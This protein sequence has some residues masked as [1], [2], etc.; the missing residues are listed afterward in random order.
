MEVLESRILIGIAHVVKR[1]GW[2]IEFVE[3]NLHVNNKETDLDFGTLL[4]IL[5]APCNRS[6][7]IRSNSASMCKAGPKLRAGAWTGHTALIVLL[8]M[9]GVTRFGNVRLDVGWL[10]AVCHLDETTDTHDCKVGCVMMMGTIH[11][12][13]RRRDSPPTPPGR[14]TALVLTLGSALGDTVEEKPS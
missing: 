3:K 9:T 1:L 7:A 14:E 11:A 12:V 13:K 6:M 8:V 10:V 4:T 2:L 5:T